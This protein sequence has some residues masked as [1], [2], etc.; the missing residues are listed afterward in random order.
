MDEQSATSTGKTLV[1]YAA[2]HFLAE[3]LACELAFES[4]CVWACGSG[5]WSVCG[6]EG[7]YERDQRPR[8]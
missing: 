3:I 8:G 2:N 7:A 6:L 4:A 5:G 1:C